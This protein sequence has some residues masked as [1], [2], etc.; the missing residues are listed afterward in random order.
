M[1]EKYYIYVGC[2]EGRFEIE[3]GPDKGKMRNYANMLV[4]MLG[5]L[6]R[7]FFI[8]LL[9]ILFLGQVSLKVKL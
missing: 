3:G 1:G 4:L 5:R 2:A 6:F 7:L 8:Y 9:R